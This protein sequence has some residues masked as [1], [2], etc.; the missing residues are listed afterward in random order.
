[1]VFILLPITTSKASSVQSGRQAD[2]NMELVYPLV[3]LANPVAQESIN[4]DI[5]NYVEDFKNKYYTGYYYNVKMSYKVMYEDEKYLSIILTFTH[6]GAGA[7]HEMYI[8]SAIVYDKDTGEHIPLGYFCNIKNAKQLDIQLI[9]G[10]ATLYSQLS[11]KLIYNQTSKHVTYITPYYYLAGNGYIYLVYQIY[12]LS[13]F[14]NGSTVIKLGPDAID[15]L[16][17]VNNSQ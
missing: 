4:S 17:R 5:A 8:R 2:V 13:S 14:S 15:Y 9:T 3:Y 11:D 1:M 7:P 6:Y 16:N 10:L 12:E